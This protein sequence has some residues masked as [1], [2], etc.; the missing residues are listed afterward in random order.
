MQFT[1]AIVSR[2]FSVTAAAHRI[3]ALCA[4]KNQIDSAEDRPFGVQTGPRM[5]C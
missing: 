2:D 5:E 1:S 3:A 4:A